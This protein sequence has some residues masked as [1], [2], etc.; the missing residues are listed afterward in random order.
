MQTSVRTGVV[1]A[2]DRLL[3][4]FSRRCSMSRTP[5][6]DL[7]IG[8]GFANLFREDGQRAAAKVVAGSLSHAEFAVASV[9][10]MLEG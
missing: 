8:H 9:K 7:N 6:S 4:G 10:R 2:I 3:L 5:P 1:Q